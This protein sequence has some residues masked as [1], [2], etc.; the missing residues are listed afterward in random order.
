MERLLGDEYELFLQSYAGEPR[1]GLR[2]NNL[3]ISVADF[4]RKSPFA[5]APAGDFEP[6][7]NEAIIAR[8][9]AR[10]ILLPCLLRRR[11]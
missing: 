9:L 4:I 6:E 11:P 2:V 1:V 7:E 3:K 8:F 10:V 5:L